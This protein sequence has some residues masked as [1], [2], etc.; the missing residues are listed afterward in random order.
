VRRDA[1]SAADAGKSRERR[2]VETTEDR[3]AKGRTELSS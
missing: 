3:E 1:A 2:I